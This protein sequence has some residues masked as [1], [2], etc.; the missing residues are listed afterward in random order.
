MKKIITVILLGSALLLPNHNVEASYSNK[1]IQAGKI[2]QIKCVEW[3]GKQYDFNKF[4]KNKILSYYFNWFMPVYK[5]S[6]INKPKPTPI[7]PEKEYDQKE[8][9]EV[10]E[11]PKE[12]KAPETEGNT[13]GE[14]QPEIEEQTDVEDVREIEDVP[15]VEEAPE[16]E[17]IPE[18]EK[19]PELPSTPEQ[20]PNP[21]VPAPTPEEEKEPVEESAPNASVSAIEQEVLNLTNA[22]RQKAGLAPLQ[23][24]QKLMESARAKSKDMSVNNYFAH[25]SPTYGSPFDQMKSFGVTYRAAAENIANGQRS[26]QDV[27]REWMD[28][29]GHRQNILTPNFTHIG[30]GY[31]ENGNYWTQQF[32]QK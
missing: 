12:E 24:D 14:Q 21:I 2:Q 1:E 13:G 10:E 31:D 20:A 11:V 4:Q 15:E 25:T 30:I 9:P 29:P 18:E 26:A 22:E 23:F 5:Y 8:V 17:L 32:I 19:A 16:V 27:V 7:I 28:S 6:I 3:N